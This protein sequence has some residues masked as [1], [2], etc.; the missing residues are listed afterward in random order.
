MKCDFAN[1][2]VAFKAGVT[3]IIRNE[4]ASASPVEIGRVIKERFGTEC[5]FENNR[6]LA[7]GSIYALKLLREAFEKFSLPF[8]ITPPK[9][10]VFQPSELIGRCDFRFGFCLAYPEKIIK[11]QPLYKERSVLIKSIADNI[12]SWDKQVEQWYKTHIS[13]SDNIFA[14]F[15]HEFLHNIHIN[16]L[17]VKAAKNSYS[18]EVDDMYMPL[19]FLQKKII[20]ETIGTHAATSKF[21]LYSETLAKM[22]TDS[23]D[24]TGTKLAS[25]P[26]DRLED[27]PKFVGDFIESQIK[28]S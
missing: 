19:N 6:T 3:S 11:K 24:T 27:F 1:N 21:E 22:I 26:M 4:V 5:D 15:L 10:K 16:S 7:V 28:V 8:Q 18:K 25:N 23:L 13:S 17:N 9:I 12:T 20:K 2:N 14:P